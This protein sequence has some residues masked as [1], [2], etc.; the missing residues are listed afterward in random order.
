MPEEFVS[1]SIRLVVSD[2]AK[3]PIY[4]IDSISALELPFPERYPMPEISFEL[5]AFSLLTDGN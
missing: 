4:F 5:A 2:S 1:G 3:Y